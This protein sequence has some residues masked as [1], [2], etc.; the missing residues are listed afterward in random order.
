MMYASHKVGA[1]LVAIEVSDIIL[2][3]QIGFKPISGLAVMSVGA[4]IG[5][6]IP[7][8]DE[9]NS[10]ISR[11]TG[12]L[13][14]P[15]RIGQALTKFLCMLPGPLKHTF[16]KLDRVV[17][18]RGIL[19]WLVTWLVINLLPL[20]AFGTRLGITQSIDYLMAGYIGLIMGIVSHIL[21]DTVFGGTM[22]LFPLTK[23]KI[24]WS[25][26]KT[27]G[28]VEYIT[29]SAMFVF[30]GKELVHYILKYIL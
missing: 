29:C 11:K 14:L 30:T 5:A 18:H 9:K 22:L 24:A 15:I 17:S 21:L 6:A 23:K 2:R 12:L 16:R 10:T 27:G 7:D 28:P 3:S 19:H 1:V 26:F 25:P 20:M 13:L 4:M 8:A